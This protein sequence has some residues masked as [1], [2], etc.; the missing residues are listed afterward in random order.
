MV[1]DENGA[2]QR[3]SIQSLNIAA[4]AAT[5]C[6]RV[7]DDLVGNQLAAQEGIDSVDIFANK[8]NGMLEA[9]KNAK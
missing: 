8:L 4:N 6:L 7:V 1:T 2:R 3:A 9:K 5:V